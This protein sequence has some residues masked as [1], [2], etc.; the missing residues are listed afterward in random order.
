MFFH[1]AVP[2]IPIGKSKSGLTNGNPA[3]TR[4]ILFL[5][6]TTFWGNIF[7]EQLCGPV[8]VGN[9]Q[10]GCLGKHMNQISVWIKVILP[11]RFN[12]TVNNG[13]AL[14]P[15]FRIC[16]QLVL[17]AHYKGF[18]TAFRTVIEDLQLPIPQT[19][20]YTHSDAADEL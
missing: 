6:N 7:R 11:G 14:G 12:Q 3:F 18:H 2:I 15:A 20:S 16:K 5:C 9:C 10:S 1:T 8:L 13:A 4:Y 19:V 17:P